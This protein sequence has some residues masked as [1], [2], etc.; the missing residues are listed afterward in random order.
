M[1][2]KGH[3]CISLKR[4]HSFSSEGLTLVSHIALTV[5][6]PSQA[7]PPLNSTVSPLFAAS[8]KAKLWFLACANIG[9]LLSASQHVGRR[10]KPNTRWVHGW[11]WE[12]WQHWPKESTSLCDITRSS[13]PDLLFG[14][15]CKLQR[16]NRFA[17]CLSQTVTKE[18]LAQRD[19]ERPQG[20]GMSG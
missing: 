20:S 13:N 7:A 2:E 19:L 16:R 10:T 8:N 9:D 15:F 14:V 11:D 18:D 12:H 1:P 5:I 17:H 4:L 6:I 3:I